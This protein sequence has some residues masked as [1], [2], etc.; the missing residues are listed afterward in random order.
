MTFHQVHIVAPPLRSSAPNG[1]RVSAGNR[2]MLGGKHLLIMVTGLPDPLDKTDGADMT[3]IPT[4]LYSPARSPMPGF[5][6][7]LR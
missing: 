2:G 6:R 7:E 5:T 3:G 4:F 1:N